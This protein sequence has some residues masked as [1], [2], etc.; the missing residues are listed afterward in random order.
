MDPLISS[1]TTLMLSLY[2]A[3]VNTN[4][5]FGAN[6]AIMEPMRKVPGLL[7]SLAVL[8]GIVYFFYYKTPGFVKAAAIVFITASIIGS[9]LV[10]LFDQKAKSKP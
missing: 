3:C 8:S 2:H 5:P 1:E 7:M 6:R 10:F 9:I 4:Y